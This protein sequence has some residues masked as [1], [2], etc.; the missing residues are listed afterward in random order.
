MTRTKLTAFQTSPS[1][2]HY[3]IRNPSYQHLH[4]YIMLTQEEL[5]GEV[6]GIGF[7]EESTVCIDRKTIERKYFHFSCLCS[8]PCS[9][10]QRGRKLPAVDVHH[11]LCLRVPRTTKLQR[12]FREI[13]GRDEEVCELYRESKP[14]VRDF[15]VPVFVTILIN[16]TLMS[17]YTLSAYAWGV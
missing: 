11:P 14:V 5:R 13:R 16:F 3:T 9:R 12:D 7:A 17:P 8:F 15:L 10:L 6:A 1:F 2:Y 4:I